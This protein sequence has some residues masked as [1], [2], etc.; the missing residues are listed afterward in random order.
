MLTVFEDVRKGHCVR[1]TLSSASAA[2]TA[3][4]AGV[5]AGA[6]GVSGWV[7]TKGAADSKVAGGTTDAQKPVSFRRQSAL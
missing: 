5:G 2:T 3:S 4:T 6:G 7:E 1:N